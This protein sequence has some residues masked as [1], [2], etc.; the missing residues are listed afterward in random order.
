MVRTKWPP[1]HS[2]SEGFLKGQNV[3]PNDRPGTEAL[4]PQ[5]KPS[6]V[7]TSTPTP[8]PPNCRPASSIPSPLFPTLP[9]GC[10]WGWG[11]QGGRPSLQLLSEPQRVGGNR[12]RAGEGAQVHRA[13]Y[14]M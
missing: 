9:P 12:K 1:C 8:V 5:G 2:G 4:M 13:V 3:L 10:M 11:G 7:H 6:E 14:R